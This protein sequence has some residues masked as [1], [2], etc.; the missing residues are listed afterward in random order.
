[1]TDDSSAERQA[2]KAAFPASTLLLCAF[3]VCQALWRWLWESKHQIEKFER[4]AKM[5]KFRTV[6]FSHDEVE[7][8]R[9]MDE[10]CNDDHEQ[11]SK[12]MKSLR[13]RMNEWAICYL[14]TYSTYGHNTNNIIESS[15]RIFK[16]VVLERCKAFNAAALVDFIFK[17]LEN[18]HKRCLIKFASYRITKPEIQYNS[19]CNKTNDLKVIQIDNTSYKVSSH[20]NNDIYYTV[21]V[22]D[23]FEHCEC[24]FGQGGKFCKHI[25]AIQL[26]GFNIEN[27]VNLSTKHRIELGNLAIGKDFDHT[28]MEPMDLANDIVSTNNSKRK[29]TS[30]ENMSTFFNS[31][32]PTDESNS[33]TEHETQNME[34]N[35]HEQHLNLEINVLQNNI[36]RIKNIAQSNPNSLMLKN[37][38]QFNKQ[39]EKITSLSDLVDFNFN[40]LRRANLI[41]TQPTSRSRRK[42]LI[43]SGAKR[44]QAGRPS[45]KEDNFKQRKKQKVR[46]LSKN[47]LNNLPHAKS[48]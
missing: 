37:I 42:R 28:F 18:Y 33:I 25:C 17:V 29:K 31:M 9:G 4:Q 10:L 21:K 11:F 1:M 24:A 3:H 12:H 39:L 43:T 22:Y 2:L 26:N 20:S 35:D 38:K 44:I 15:I 30:E 19:F 40:K 46:S 27:V 36:D 48:H 13:S 32:L 45:S 34:N 16:D 5:L 23:G 8:K 14:Q 7:A 41:G 47:L 6:L